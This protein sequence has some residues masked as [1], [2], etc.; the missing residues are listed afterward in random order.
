MWK[1]EKQFRAEKPETINESD[2]HFDLDNYK[3]WLEEKLSNSVDLLIESESTFICSD[4]IDSD[5]KNR[6]QELTRFLS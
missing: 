2:R 5:L 6:F 4:S 1:Y 3:D